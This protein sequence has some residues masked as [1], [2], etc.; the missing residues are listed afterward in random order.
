MC[1]ETNSY[2][3]PTC[4]TKN[5]INPELK[6]NTS[7]Q[8][9]STNQP[10]YDET[11]MSTRETTLN[12]NI[13]NFNDSFLPSP[14]EEEDWSDVPSHNKH[15]SAHETILSTTTSSE[16]DTPS[17]FEDIKQMRNSNRKRPILAYLNITTN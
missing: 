10:E 17:V 16:N 5:V 4:I 7:K 3:C 8:D 11:Q 13:Q 12:H 1:S 2:T 14:D 6:Q 15:G 9:P